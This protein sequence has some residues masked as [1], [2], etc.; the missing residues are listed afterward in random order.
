MAHH[1]WN[2][3]DENLIKYK[4]VE[5]IQQEYKDFTINIAKELSI[6]EL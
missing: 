4:V 3:D 6:N 5:I 2:I 1:F